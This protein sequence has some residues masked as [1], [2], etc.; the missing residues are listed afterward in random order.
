MTPRKLIERLEASAALPSGGG[1]RFNGYGL[2]GLPFR[3]GH[4]LAMR[5]FQVSSMGPGYTSVWHRAPSGTWTFYADV[6][7][8]ISCARYFCAAGARAVETGIHLSWRDDF[9]F[10]V[11]VPAARLDWE[12]QVAATPATW[13]LNAMA[14]SLPPGAWRNRAVLSAMGRVAGVM[15]RAGRV[16]LTGR[17]PSRQRF[18]AGPRT[19]WAVGGSRAALAGEEFGPPGAVNPQARLGD[20]W[21]PQ[22][23]VLAVG[24]AIFDPFNP[25]E[26][27]AL[28]TTPS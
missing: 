2:M 5:R 1:E 15:L 17:V 22:R 3:S 11:E 14:R 24:G 25:L 27:S 20:F 16:R 21:I 7:A 9:A 18:M 13:T 26:H 23:G 12:V 8:S 6:G 4:V 28:M 10:T 19:V